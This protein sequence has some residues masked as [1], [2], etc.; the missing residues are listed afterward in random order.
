MTKEITIGERWKCIYE[1]NYSP[2]VAQ[3]VLD[4][5]IK[6]MENHTAST[7]GE[8]IHQDDDCIID[9]PELISD[10]V[11]DILKPKFLREE[12]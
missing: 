1:I 2:E 7:S 11:D 10:I 12:E 8:G 3:Q 6:W 4:K 5:V 9:A